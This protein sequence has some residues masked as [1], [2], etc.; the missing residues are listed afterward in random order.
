MPGI[1]IRDFSDDYAVFALVP[2]VT[3]FKNNARPI[4][5]QDMKKFKAEYFIKNFKFI[6]ISF[7][8]P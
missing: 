6:S 7:Y 4:W 8:N 3:H 2:T 5:K 1:A